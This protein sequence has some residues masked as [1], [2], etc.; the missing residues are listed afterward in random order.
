MHVSRKHVP[1]KI[2]TFADFIVESLVTVQQ[3]RPAVAA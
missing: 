1:V 3:P 2:R